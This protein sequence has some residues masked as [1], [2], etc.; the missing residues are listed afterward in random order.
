MLVVYYPSSQPC[1]LESLAA[2]LQIQI[3]VGV[4]VNTPFFFCHYFQGFF[5]AFVTSGLNSAKSYSL[6]QNLET[7][8][9]VKSGCLV[10]KWY[11]T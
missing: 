5:D 9:R 6:K 4:N 2:F 7:A 1:D 11:F 8:T 10:V 3:V